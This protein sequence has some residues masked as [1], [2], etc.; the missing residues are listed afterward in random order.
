MA[1][2]KTISKKTEYTVSLGSFRGVDR[3]GG[4]ISRSRL[5]YSENMYRDYDGDG[6]GV[7]ESIPGFRRLYSFDRRIHRIYHHKTSIDPN[8]IIVHAEDSIFA[9]S[10][11]YLDSL[12]TL[13][14][15]GTVADSRSSGFAYGDVFYLLDGESL[16]SLDCYG[17]FHTLTEGD[18]RIYVPTTYINGEEYEQRNLLTNSFC[19]KYTI[20]DPSRYSYGTPELVYTVTDPDKL[21][22]AV[23]GIKTGYTG[24]VY[25][26]KFAD[27]AGTAYEVREISESALQ[28][29]YGITGVIM[30]NGIRSIANNAFQGCSGMTF[31]VIPD[32]VTSIGSYALSSCAELKDIYLGRGVSYVS[33]SAFDARSGITVHYAGTANEFYEIDEQTAFVNHTVFCNEKYT[34][35]YVSLPISSDAAA[36]DGVYLDG[37]ALDYE[38]ITE[39]GR[40]TSLR[41]TFNETW[42]ALGKTVVIKGT[43][44]TSQ[45]S[46]EKK[47]KSF[48]DSVIGKRKGGFSAITRCTVAVLF[49]GRI[50][51]SGNPSLPNTVFFTERDSTGENNPLYVG[52]MNYFN[53]GLGAYP[54]A[55]LLPVRDSLAVFKGGDDGGGSIFYHTPTETGDSVVPKAYP[56]AYV[57]SGVSAY[58]P[59][60][61]F[62]DDPVFLSPGGLSA[63][64][65]KNI[66]YERNIVCR[67]HNVNFD[68]LKEDLSAASLSVWLGYLAVCTEGNIYLADSRATFR[69]ETG[70]TE[71]EWFILSGIGCYKEDARV[72]RYDSTAPDGY[73]IHPEPDSEVKETV[74]SDY[75]NG[76]MIYYTEENGTRYTAYPTD[77]WSGGVF[78]PAVTA[79]TCGELLLFGTARGELCVFNND[80]RGVPPDSLLLNSEFDI[81]EYRER[82]GT[83]IHQ[84][85]YYFDRHTPRYGIRTKFDDC[86]IPHL[87][88]NTVKNSLVVKC[89]SYPGNKMHL[90][91][92][93]DKTGYKE[94]ASF[95]GGGLDF[96]SLDFSALS[97]DHTEYTTIPFRE[98]EKDW[99]EKQISI[100]C[101]SPH[102]P[103]GILS[104]SYRYTVKGNI[105][106]R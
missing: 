25:I 104:I 80:K 41:I 39:S 3:D 10:R 30:A 34:S 71:Y 14:A 105:K 27:I 69:H 81:E 76:D 86:D 56:I 55:S 79:A 97:F 36:I 50:F 45:T 43:L 20:A 93:T 4:N 84:D 70:G 91:V 92:G 47:R 82:M 62:L 35:I 51:Y 54:V 78:S 102:S 49:D 37:E 66:S 77:E 73:S 68:L 88:K 19:E 75:L 63:L 15:N 64:A 16:H 90:E 11:D 1:S 5:A 6:G 101:D 40:P 12:G 21:W 29:Q 24:T 53:D 17:N 65:E 31:V 83:R 18:S 57:H 22:C 96:S 13:T 99:V 9:F 87:A 106:K 23:S 58:G 100:Y 48:L 67:S 46:T 33:D 52:A 103:I 8:R 61:S 60:V 26:P 95:T 89:K 42:D 7:I 94:I 28:D 98:R 74:Y 44:S 2:R 85:F 72:F 32:T 59:S 38:T